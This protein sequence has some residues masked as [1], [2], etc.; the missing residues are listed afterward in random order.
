MTE[1]NKS[2]LSS[3]IVYSDGFSEAICAVQQDRIAKSYTRKIRVELGFR[4][5]GGLPIFLPNAIYRHSLRFDN[6][7][8]AD[9]TAQGSCNK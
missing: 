5:A 6:L 7:C 3:K 2:K 1:G 8:G 9:E 4:D